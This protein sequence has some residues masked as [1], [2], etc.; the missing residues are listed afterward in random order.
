M[1]KIVIVHDIRQCL[2]C[3]A[4]SGSTTGAV[5][6]ISRAETYDKTHLF[7]RFFYFLGFVS[8]WCVVIQITYT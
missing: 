4:F 8:L 2:L 5:T 1:T 7:Q 3:V 6:V